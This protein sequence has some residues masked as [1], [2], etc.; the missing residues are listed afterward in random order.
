MQ[1]VEADD[2]DSAKT[3]RLEA[4]AMENLKIAEKISKQLDFNISFATIKRN[5]TLDEQSP[6]TLKSDWIND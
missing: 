1:K 6:R 2:E 4:I 3:S 5:D